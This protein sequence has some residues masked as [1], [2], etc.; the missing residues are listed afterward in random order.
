MLRIISSENEVSNDL[1]VCYKLWLY[2]TE[3]NE[4]LDAVRNGECKIDRYSCKLKSGTL[5]KGNISESKIEGRYI[6]EYA[7]G[8]IYDGFF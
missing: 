1:Y 3:L 4:L 6:V 5:Y 8:R 7:D 2:K